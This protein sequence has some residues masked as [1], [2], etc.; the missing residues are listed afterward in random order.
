MNKPKSKTHLVSVRVDGRVNAEIEELLNDTHK[1]KAE[2][3]RALL[4][5]GLFAYKRDLYQTHGDRVH[6]S[7]DKSY[8]AYEREM[9]DDD[10]HY[11]ATRFDQLE[12]MIREHKEPVLTPTKKEGK[13][14]LLDSFF[15]K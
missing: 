5:R 2:L 6:H 12:A 15:K 13:K 11:I 1:D 10:L 8:Y 4:V 14:T 3:L 7:I 9:L